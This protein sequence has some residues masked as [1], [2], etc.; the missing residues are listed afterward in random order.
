MDSGWGFAI[1]TIIA[2]LFGRIV[3]V[4]VQKFLEKASESRNE[5][6][7]IF[8]TLIATRGSTFAADHVRA[9]SM[10]DLAFKFSEKITSG[11]IKSLI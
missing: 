5:K 3:A 7:W 6:M 11:D 10:I 8:R 1:G 9:L 2:T 4:Q